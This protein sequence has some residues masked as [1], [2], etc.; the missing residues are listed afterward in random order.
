MLSTI[1]RPGIKAVLMA[2][3]KALIRELL[4]ENLEWAL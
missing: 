3:A 2:L 1:V 4:L